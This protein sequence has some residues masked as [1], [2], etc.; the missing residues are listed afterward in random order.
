LKIV[1]KIS[2]TECKQVF[3]KNFSVNAF[4]KKYFNSIK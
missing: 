3:K 4:F 2:K 1:E